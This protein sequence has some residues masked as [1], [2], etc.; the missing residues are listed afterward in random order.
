[1]QVGG[2]DRAQYSARF[3]WPVFYLVEITWP[4][5][6]I[7]VHPISLPIYVLGLLGLGLFAWRRKTEDKFLLIWFVVVYVFFTFIPNKQWRYV[8]TLF[9]VLAISAASLVFFA[10]NRSA[11][12]WR[13]TNTSSVKKKLHSIAGGLLVVLTVVSVVYSSYDAY[14]MAERDQIHV[15]I[16]E[17]TKYAVENMQENDAIVVLAAFNLFNRDMVKFYLQ[18]DR[19]RP[20]KVFQY[21][22][23]P[24]DAFKP[25]FNVTILT[26]LCE[27]QNAKY[28][29]LYEY[30][31]E[32]PYFQSNLTAMQIYY[33]TVSSGR[34]THEYRVG[35]FP[36]TITIFSFS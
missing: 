5:N 25:D 30:G 18:S 34:F 7:P 17:A 4:F 29:F 3:P 23:L 8:T 20:N 13:H 16:E 14:L 32:V 24:V 1:M 19:A 22:E 11:E 9:P 26:A 33:E 28:V 35:S 27:E 12:A 31:G 2:E 21:P 15:P 10:Y 6:D 36:R